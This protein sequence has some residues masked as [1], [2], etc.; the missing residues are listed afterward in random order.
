MSVDEYDDRFEVGD[1][2]DAGSG[3][4]DGDSD[5]SGNNDGGDYDLEGGNEDDPTLQDKNHKSGTNGTGPTA[6]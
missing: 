1:A 5:G 3:S 2:S 6:K 4:F